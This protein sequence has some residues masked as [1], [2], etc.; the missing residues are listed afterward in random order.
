MVRDSAPQQKYSSVHDLAETM[1]G[2]EPVKEA[3][4]VKVLRSD[5]KVADLDQNFPRV[6]RLEIEAKINKRT[7]ESE[8]MD[9]IVDATI[10]EEKART[11]EQMKQIRQ[12]IIT[13]RPNQVAEVDRSL[14]RPAVQKKVT[15]RNR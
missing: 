6:E 1:K 9:Y 14:K 3:E 5:K 12:E 2:N 4:I 15:G 13:A 7:T 11:P 10:K 8:I